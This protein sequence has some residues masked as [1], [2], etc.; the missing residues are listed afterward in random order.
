MRLTLRTLLAYLDEILEPKD[1]EEIGHKI[2]ESEFASSLLQRIRDVM[3]RLRLQAPDVDE[4]DT[5]LDPN[6]V[7]EYLDNTL[8][9]DRVADFEKVCL[10]SDMHLAEVA[11]CHQIL[12][13]V[14]GEPAEID[15]KSREHMYTLP[16]VS[17]ELDEMA[18]TVN[19]DEGEA[20]V[21]QPPR[22][23]R[24][25]PE[26]PE[27]L[28][29]RPKRKRWGLLAV[30]LAIA[31]CLLAVILAE[32]GQLEFLGISPQLAAKQVEEGQHAD[33]GPSSDVEDTQTI[34]DADFIDIEPD[35]AAS[36]GDTS[37]SDELVAP[38]IVERPSVLP[39]PPVVQ[40][41][42]GT[43]Q[44]EQPAAVPDSTHLP[45]VE[46]SPVELPGDEQ[47]TDTPL[48]V[49]RPPV[50]DVAAEPPAEP[51]PSAAG[52]AVA[53]D[54]PE[55]IGRFMSDNSVLLRLNA[56]R[57]DWARVPAQDIL[58]PE[59]E[60][61]SLPTFRPLIAMTA[62]LTLR[63]VDGTRI[64][65]EPADADGVPGLKISYGRVI[66][67][68]V[69]RPNARLRLTLGAG[70]QESGLLAFGDAETTLTIEV[71][72][73]LATGSNPENQASTLKTVFSVVTGQV[74]WNRDGAE[75]IEIAASQKLAFGGADVSGSAVKP[76]AMNASP[77]WIVADSLSLIDQKAS[78]TVEADLNAGRPI[79]LSLKELADHRKK[80]VRRLAV[81]S[82]GHIGIFD[83]MAAVLNDPEQR[84]TRPDYI[85]DLR[86]SLALGPQVAANV[87][88]AFEREYGS[89]AAALYRLL[90][91]FTDEQLGK[92][93][94]R[95]GT[96]KV[97]ETLVDYLDHKLLV[98]RVLG[99]WN[100]QTITGLGLYYQPEQPFN[101]R[102]QSVRNWRQR[103]KEGDIRYRKSR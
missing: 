1:A 24:P 88:E 73:E 82:L 91:G 26:I 10:E 16:Q 63:L 72:H 64:A 68:T 19:T 30:G 18:T 87:R 47:P 80:E 2:E 12:A 48:V 46:N 38:P 22:Q 56:D 76:A 62:G 93:D 11:A 49:Q 57:K 17:A 101:K 50:P 40:T 4:Q 52:S 74:Q 67:Q 79:S 60:L 100:L 61:L 3:R 13:M 97:D 85:S 7:A 28:R 14:L 99:F 75:P 55:R 43:A 95:L 86:A 102:Q 42:D 94:A 92:T 90:W 23:K 96:G 78:A 45:D 21:T 15:P 6:T 103:L 70:G 66:V 59:Y 84:L 8:A 36:G 41:P 44:P 33:E 65:F 34:V 39:P 37:D 98:F 35:N 83:Q 32:T 5:A 31:G 25:R 27:Y 51:E 53:Q 20:S 58:T 81:R 77:D 54:M 9:A 69:G 89:D 29:E 71:S